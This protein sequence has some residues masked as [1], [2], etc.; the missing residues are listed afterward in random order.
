LKTGA[1]VFGIMELLAQKLADP[2]EE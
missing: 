1:K 2:D